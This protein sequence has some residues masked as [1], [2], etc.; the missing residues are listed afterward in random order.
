L[1]YHV[2]G[3]PTENLDLA[4]LSSKTEGYS[5]ADLAHLCDSAA[6]LAMEA[7]M[8]SGEPRPLQQVDFKKAMKDVKPSTRP[9]FD[10]ARNY[11][12]FANEGGVYDELL[13]Y[14]R[15]ARMM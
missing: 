8:V 1:R 15:A 12:M 14:L 3:K 7:S 4:W 5:G 9:W 6:E 11:A 10:T 2:S 13:E